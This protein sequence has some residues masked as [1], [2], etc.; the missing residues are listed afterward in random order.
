MNQKKFF[1]PLLPAIIGLVLLV[2]G[3]WVMYTA[4]K[5][6]TLPVV[7]WETED[8]EH[9]GLIWFIAFFVVL[10]PAYAF[11]IS[12]GVQCLQK[13]HDDDSSKS[14]SASERPES[15]SHSSSVI[16][17]SCKHGI[18]TITREQTKIH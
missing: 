15:G 17:S 2:W 3:L 6:G 5:Y 10:L 13:K 14:S 12:R 9:F 11:A 4:F 8:N 18:T 1:A 7:G 16:I